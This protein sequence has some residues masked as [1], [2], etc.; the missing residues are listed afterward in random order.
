ML[1]LA[2]ICNGKSG[3][4]EKMGSKKLS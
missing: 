1:N 2:I 3:L 4:M